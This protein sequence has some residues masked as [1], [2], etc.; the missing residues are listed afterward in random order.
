MSWIRVPAAAGIVL[1]LSSTVSIAD[2]ASWDGNKLYAEC[3]K[4]TAPCAAYLAGVSEF[5]SKESGIALPSAAV[6]FP[7]G[8]SARQIRDVVF[9]Q[10]EAYP[11]GRAEPAVYIA[12]TAMKEAWPCPE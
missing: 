2:Q 3:R 8:T 10:L 12:L 1:C 4:K 6:C 9:K 7:E 11:Q 5:A